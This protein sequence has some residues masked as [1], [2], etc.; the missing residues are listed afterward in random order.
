MCSLISPVLLVRC[1]G[2]FPPATIAMRCA[3]ATLAALAARSFASRFAPRMSAGMSALPN[4]SSAQMA[5]VIAAVAAAFAT[6]TLL[7]SGTATS[8]SAAL[9]TTLV[10]LATLPSIGLRVDIIWISRVP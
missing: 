9:G 2:R 5:H 1:I 7:L 4:L 8:T 6:V 10:I 3:R